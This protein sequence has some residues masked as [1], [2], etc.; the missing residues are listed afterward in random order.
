MNIVYDNLWLTRRQQTTKNLGKSSVNSTLVRESQPPNKTGDEPF[1]TFGFA[2]LDPT[3]SPFGT[4][5]PSPTTTDNNAKTFG[6]TTPWRNNTE[7]LQPEEVPM[8]K[9]DQF[10]NASSRATALGF[11]TKGKSSFPSSSVSNPNAFGGATFGS[12]FGNAFGG[13]K[14]SSFAAPIGDAKWGGGDGL[15]TSFG[16]PAKD[17]E[18]DERSESEEEGPGDALKEQE[19][20]EVNDKFQQQDSKCSTTP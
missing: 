16:A 6:S 1:V 7:D 5:S 20:C 15:V 3:I 12:G 18:D 14:L 13:A 8:E 2:L 19:G 11:G 4:L 17:E 9:V 10:R